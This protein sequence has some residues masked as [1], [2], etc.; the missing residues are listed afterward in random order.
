MGM[1]DYIKLE[2]KCP[3][4]KAKVDGFQS[5]DGGCFL[6]TLDYWEV[7]NFYSSCNKC[8]TWIEYDLHPATNPRP[9]ISL[10]KYKRT[11]RVHNGRYRT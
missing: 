1:F 8:G 10:S 11:T 4:C 3:K 6:D 5:K 7:D 2:V 9:K